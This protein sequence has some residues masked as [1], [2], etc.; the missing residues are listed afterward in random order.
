MS[1]GGDSVV[2]RGHPIRS[3]AA[4]AAAVV[5]ALTVGVP[6]VASAVLTGKPVG[7]A[8]LAPRYRV[9]AKIQ[10]DGLPVAIA[11]DPLTNTTYAAQQGPGTH[12]SVAVINNRTDKEIR[13]LPVFA[14]TLAFDS[15]T[16]A[17]YLPTELGVVVIGGRARR[18]SARLPMVAQFITVDPRTGHVYLAVHNRMGASILVLSDRT[19]KVVARIRF[20]ASATFGPMAASPARGVIYAEV[21]IP[22]KPGGI[23]VIGTHS[24]KV[25]A[26]IGTGGGLAVDDRNNVLAALGGSSLTLIDGRTHKVRKVVNLL[27]GTPQANTDAVAVSPGTHTVFA[28]AE[29]DPGGWVDVVSE[30]TGRI[31]KTINGGLLRSLAVDRRRDVVFAVDYTGNDVLVIDAR[32]NGVIAKLG[33]GVRPDAVAVNPVTGRAYVANFAYGTVSVLAPAGV[34]SRQPAAWAGAASRPAVDRAAA[35]QAANSRRGV[36]G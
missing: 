23:W 18:V 26:R 4:I 13:R 36:C 33:V 35:G 30:R 5:C 24:S 20:P 31:L 3:S 22:N 14:Y 1:A 27:Q 15:R 16:D 25:L 34:S 8:Q 29:C 10:L 12:Y 9:V 7:P 2:Q 19:N 21:G 17:F 28:S 6:A 11:E 32:T